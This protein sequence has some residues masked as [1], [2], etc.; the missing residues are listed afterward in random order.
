MSEDTVFPAG[1]NVRT[2]L[3]VGFEWCRPPAA[4]PL[5]SSWVVV[6]ALDH[7]LVLCRVQQFCDGELR[8]GFRRVPVSYQELNEFET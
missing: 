7:P 8:G 6:Y 1:N 4:Q 5:L 3:D 2:V